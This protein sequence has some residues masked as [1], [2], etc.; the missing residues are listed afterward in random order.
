MHRVKFKLF[1][2]DKVHE[3]NEDVAVNLQASGRGKILKQVGTR[4]P[5]GVDL[6]KEEKKERMLDALRKAREAKKAKKDE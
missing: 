2:D 5:V 3:Y 1:Q 6:N 4:T